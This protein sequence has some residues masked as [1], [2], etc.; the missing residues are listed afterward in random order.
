ME[1]WCSETREALDAFLEE[2]NRMIEHTHYPFALHSN[3]T[4]VHK[5]RLIQERIKAI[6]TSTNHDTSAQ[7]KY[8]TAILEYLGLQMSQSYRKQSPAVKTLLMSIYPEWEWSREG[9]DIN[10]ILRRLR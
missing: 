2:L 5:Q 3:D 4:Y 9:V 1:R 8:L 7:K 10:E 6:L